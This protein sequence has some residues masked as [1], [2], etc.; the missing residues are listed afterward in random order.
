VFKFLYCSVGVN[1]WTSERER[2]RERLMMIAR[3]VP[4]AWNERCA[5]LNYLFSLWIRAK[6]V[7]LRAFRARLVSTFVD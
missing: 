4:G 6:N 7:I 1:E 3:I 5:A 2:E